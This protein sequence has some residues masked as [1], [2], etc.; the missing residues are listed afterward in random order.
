[1]GILYADK[2]VQRNYHDRVATLI[3]S[4][5]MDWQVYYKKDFKSFDLFTG[6]PV[7]IK[8][9]RLKHGVLKGVMSTTV[10]D[11][12]E[13]PFGLSIPYS[14]VEVSVS[15]IEPGDNKV[16]KIVIREDFY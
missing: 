12:W 11:T 3:A 14:I 10:K 15:W 8:D 2:Q 4:G 5:E 6:R 13:N 16:R 1:M 7:D 9:D